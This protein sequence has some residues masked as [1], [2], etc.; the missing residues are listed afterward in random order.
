[1]DPLIQLPTDILEFFYQDLNDPKTY[2]VPPSIEKLIN[3][4][5][6]LTT[7]NVLEVLRIIQ[8]FRQL[9]HLISAGNLNGTTDNP[10]TQECFVAPHYDVAVA[11]Y[12]T[13]NFL[14]HGF[15]LIAEHFKN[16][17]RPVVITRQ[18]DTFDIGTGFLLGNIH[19][20][21]TARHVVEHAKLI[22]ILDCNN[23]P[24]KASSVTFHQNK[25][26]DIAI[27][28]IS[29]HAFIKTPVFN[30]IDGEILEDV[31]TIGYP[32]VPGFDAIQVYEKASINNSFKFSKGQ[33]IAR[34][35][36]YLDGIEYLLIN[37]KVKGGNSGSPVI[38]RKGNVIGM[39][40]QIPLDSQDASRLDSLGY[41]IV[42]P[43][44]EIVKM[45]HGP[46]KRPDIVQCEV[47]NL[48]NGF[49]LRK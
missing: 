42:T 15:R 43:R 10:M 34:D 2:R 31:L 32:P 9:G 40:V 16:T 19:T 22:Q 39:V 14:I 13:Y 12:G 25:N 49:T 17:V 6:Y 33:I 3:Q 41:G 27:I 44:S 37:A 38:N 46:S 8:Q 29:E 20:F 4:P 47:I 5:K 45:L 7:I 23:R 28:L 18:D 26:I 24:V 35:R 30:A 11:K 21:I 48:E 1:M 36:S